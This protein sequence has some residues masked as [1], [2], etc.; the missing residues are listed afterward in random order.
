MPYLFTDLPEVPVAL[1][2]H[3]QVMVFS[4]N[5]TPRLYRISDF[6]L[7]RLSRVLDKRPWIGTND[8][9]I[10]FAYFQRN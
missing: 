5:R 7:G 8:E 3:Y 6:S 10:G 2:R 4:S 9:Q 1:E